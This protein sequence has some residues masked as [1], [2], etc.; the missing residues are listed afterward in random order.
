MVT[1][2]YFIPFANELD[3]DCHWI[4]MLVTDGLVSV[5]FRKGANSQQIMGDGQD[6]AG[7]FTMY[8]TIVNGRLRL[9]KQYSAHSFELVGRLQ[10]AGVMCGYWG[11]PEW[12]GGEFL[13]VRQKKKKTR[14]PIGTDFFLPRRAR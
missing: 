1:N 6:L 10:E 5:T 11:T 7:A 9:V 3:L 12:Y 2:D 8:G 4:G 13:F 14:N